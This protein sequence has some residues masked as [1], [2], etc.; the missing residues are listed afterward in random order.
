MPVVG[1]VANVMHHDL[2]QP[3]GLRPLED[4][5]VQR[6]FQQLRDNGQDVYSHKLHQDKK[7]KSL[8]SNKS[9][10]M[11]LCAHSGSFYWIRPSLYIL[12]AALVIILI[13]RTLKHNTTLLTPDQTRD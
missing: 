13:L 5:F 3:L 6:A 4:R 8:T 10:E 1:E 2:H 11:A 12:G 7:C 9:H